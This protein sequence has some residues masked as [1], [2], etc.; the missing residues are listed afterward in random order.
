MIFQRE[1]KGLEARQGLEALVVPKRQ[2]L[3]RYQALLAPFIGSSSPCCMGFSKS[4]LV[5]KIIENSAALWR[6]SNL[7]VAQKI[8]LCY[9]NIMK[10]G[11]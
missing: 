4:A 7:A 8:Q 2:V 6:L 9:K 5:P 3:T 10:S 11:G 1:I